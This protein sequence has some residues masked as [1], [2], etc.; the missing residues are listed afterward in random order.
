MNRK[1]R[2]IEYLIK[3]RKAGSAEIYF[4][5]IKSGESL[6][7]VT[8]KRAL[9]KMAADGILTITGKGRATA[10]S[11]TEYGK[12]TANI[13]AAIYC[14]EEPDAR[15]GADKYNF[16]LFSTLNF[17]LFSKVELDDLNSA[18]EYYCKKTTEVSEAIHK[19]E[20]ERFVIELSWKSSKIEGNTYTLLDTELL[21][22]EGIQAAGH[23]KEE[24]QMILNHK[25]AFDYIYGNQSKFFNLKLSDLED[26]HKILVKGFNVSINL[27]SGP[28]GITGSRYR[29]LDNK[30][31]IKEAVEQL[32]LA[33]KRMPH[34][35]A[36]ALITL[37]GISY[38]QP[39]E[40]G[41]KRTARLVAN[42]ILLANNLAPLS[43]R[44]VK[45]K[46]YLEAT[47]VFYEINS[48]VPFKKIFIDQYNFA[49]RNYL[50]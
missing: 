1:Q 39:F 30:Y 16:D 46:E 36:Q 13:D 3:N 6:T 12:I 44:N 34:G 4:N 45:E 18:T 48:L 14:L 15:F 26:V 19:K 2:I 5:L 10:Y 11:L 17:D 40:D 24:A 8:V 49:A 35:Y 41:N 21:I 43:Y 29:P 27:R 38:I 28:I 31:Q 33:I 25:D 37:L 22:K 20:L 9:A 23:S 32:M 50:T 47:L 7:H 42:G